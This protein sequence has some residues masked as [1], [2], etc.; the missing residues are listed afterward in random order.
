M[1]VGLMHLGFTQNVICM[2]SSSFLLSP[3]DSINK[4]NIGIE[5][6]EYYSQKQLIGQ[7]SIHSFHQNCQH[8]V[9]PLP[10]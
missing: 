4:Y 8:F 9:L 10:Q 2:Y 7:H 5:E 3:T 1:V 6:S